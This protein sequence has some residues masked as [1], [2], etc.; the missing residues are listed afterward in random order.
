L[1][2]TLVPDGRVDI[3]D[4]KVSKLAGPKAPLFG[5]QRWMALRDVLGATVVKYDRELMLYVVRPTDW[6]PARTARDLVEAEQ[7]L[8]FD[9]HVSLEAPPGTRTPNPQIKRSRGAAVSLI[10]CKRPCWSRLSRPEGQPDQVSCPGGVGR[11][12]LVRAPSDF[13][14]RAVSAEDGRRPPSGSRVRRSRTA[15]SGVARRRAVGA[16]GPQ[17]AQDLEHTP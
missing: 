5:D 10:G 13:A 6:P 15:Q 16:D 12:Q 3:L 7:L 14:S 9:A 8:S 11:R 4:W 1:T 17:T 2:V